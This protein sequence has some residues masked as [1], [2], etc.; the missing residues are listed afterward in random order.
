[1]KYL[2]S[3]SFAL[4]SIN[5]LIAQIP[6][7]SA[8][9]NSYASEGTT[10]GANDTIAYNGISL[11]NR[12]KLRGYVDF[13]YGYGDVDA[14]GDDSRFSTSG[15]V[16]FLFDFSPVTGEVHLQATTEDVGLEQL[17]GRYSFNQDFNLSF[18]RQLTNLGYEADEAPGLFSVSKGY[19]LDVLTE[20][21][22]LKTVYS[23]IASEYNAAVAAG[24]IIGPT[25]SEGEIEK[26][27]DFRRNYKDGVRA[28]FNNGQFGFSLGIYDGYWRAED[29]FNDHVAIDIAASVVIIPGLEA[30]LGYAH[31]D[32]DDSDIGQINT[33]VEFSPGDLTLAFEYDYFD[34][35]NDADL[36][37]LMILGNYQ[38]TDLLGLTLRY[39]HEDGDNIF[40]GDDY[41][42]DRITLAFLFSITQQFGINF[43][44]SHTDVDIGD[45]S[46]DADEVYLESLFTF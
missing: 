2:I 15:D 20:H 32:L 11:G 1:M 36:W 42:S 39:S 8:V 23:E 35:H 12:V 21:E 37:D 38:I 40:Y 34:F 28:N 3:L 22:G 46:Y 25:I 14:L 33:W 45:A 44:Y 30:R 18:G 13:V 26:L 16:D 41:E 7:A 5:A 24:I 6:G 31:Q 17:F 27:I 4:F 10:L 9:A 29:D 19:F 43:E